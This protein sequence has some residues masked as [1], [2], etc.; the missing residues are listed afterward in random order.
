MLQ[1]HLARR[2]VGHEALVAQTLSYLVPIELTSNSGARPILRHLFMICDTLPLL[3]Y[4]YDDDKCIYDF[5]MLLLHCDGGGGEEDRW[6]GEAVAGG[7]GGGA[8]EGTI[9]CRIMRSR[10]HMM[11]SRVEV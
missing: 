2:H 1:V 10:W 7:D 8:L 6:L 5:K 4:D 9:T 11:G 3:D